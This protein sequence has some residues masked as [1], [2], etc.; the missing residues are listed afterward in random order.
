MF[1][2]QTSSFPLGQGLK[3]VT[4]QAHK[5]RLIGC[6]YLVNLMAVMGCDVNGKDCIDSPSNNVLV[7][8][9]LRK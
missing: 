6:V 5:K 7:Q 8:K 4:T 3:K 9:S 1:G 2:H